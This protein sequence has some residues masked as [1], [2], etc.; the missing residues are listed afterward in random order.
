MCAYREITVI[1]F[2]VR[3]GCP[4]VAWSIPQQSSGQLSARWCSKC[5]PCPESATFHG[6]GIL[7]QAFD[8]ERSP[9]PCTCESEKQEGNGLSPAE[10]YHCPT[11][12]G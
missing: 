7:E 3:G 9:E 5:M 4:V 8:G 10:E 1:L 2:I 6:P 12:G 11:L